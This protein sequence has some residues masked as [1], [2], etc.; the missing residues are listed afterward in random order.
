MSYELF[1]P[2]QTKS[3]SVYEVTFFNVKC[4]QYDL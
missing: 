2:M 3:D 1:T 4:K